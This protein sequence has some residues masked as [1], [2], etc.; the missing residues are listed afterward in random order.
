MKSSNI[1]IHACPQYGQ[2]ISASPFPIRLELFL[3][4]AKIPYSITTED[5]T[6]PYTQKTPW[7]EYKGQ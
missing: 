4:W 1:L 2:S 7:I 5:P 6:H 3:R